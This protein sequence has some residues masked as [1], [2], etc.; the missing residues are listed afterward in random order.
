MKAMYFSPVHNIKLCARHGMEYK[1]RFG[2]R[3]VCVLNKRDSQ[4]MI[5]QSQIRD[6]LELLVRSEYAKRLDQEHMMHIIK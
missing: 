3:L 2:L 6:E 1:I 5:A 4:Q